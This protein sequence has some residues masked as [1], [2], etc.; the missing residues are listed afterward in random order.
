MRA[1]RAP[2]DP[3]EQAAR[4]HVP[5]RGAEAGERGHQVHTIVAPQA[6]RERFGLSGL[7]DDAEPIAKPLHRRPG[8]EGAALERVAEAVADVPGDRREQA[9][10][11]GRRTLPSVREEET[12]GAVGVLRLARTKAGLAEEGRLLVADDPGDRDGRAEM[13]R[14]GRGRDAARAHR[15][16]EQRAREV[17]RA[18]QLV[19]P[20]SAVDVEDE[21]P[22]RVRDG[23]NVSA[24]AAEPPHQPRV[25]RSAEQLAAFGAGLRARNLVEDPADLRRREVR[26]DDE[27][28]ALA[29]ERLEAVRTELLADGRARPALPDDRRVDRAARRALPDDGRLALVRDADRGDVARIDAGHRE[30]LTS[31]RH[32]RGEDLVRVVLDVSRGGIV[33]CDLAVGASEGRTC[34][35]E[36]HRARP[37]RS[38]IEREDRSHSMLKRRMGSISR[39]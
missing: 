11:R 37:G 22:R 8:D 7:G 28:G 30:R 34:L 23:R 20:G 17:E 5:V 33:L 15:R 13:R 18:Q 31:D 6:L 10:A 4:V 12:A 16:R 32:G 19:V 35:V 27:P 1:R 24:S 9:T 29:H 39:R 2:L 26:V 3:D 21:R 14:L 36:H 25:D 38:L